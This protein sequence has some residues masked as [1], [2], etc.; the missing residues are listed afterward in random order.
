M[1]KRS[2]SAT[3]FHS[4]I[5][6][7]DSISIKSPVLLPAPAASTPKPAKHP[8]PAKSAKPGNPQ[9]LLQALHPYPSTVGPYAA[10]AEG[11]YD[12]FALLAEG[13]A[14]TVKF[15]LHFG[16]ALHAAAQPGYPVTVLGYHH[17]TP[18]GDSHLHLV[19]VEAADHPAPL[20]VE[21]LT[22][23]DESYLLN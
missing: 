3:P 10:N 16:Q 14:Y 19:R 13:T 2:T 12:R 23:Q 7:S 15:P 1:E 8:K 9:T 22:V 17:A 5:M 4:S 21:L 20:A 6:S 18:K 11:V